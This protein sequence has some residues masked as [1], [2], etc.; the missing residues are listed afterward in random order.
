[1]IDR[2]VVRSIAE[3]STLSATSQSAIAAPNRT[4]I[5]AVVQKLPSHAAANPIPASATAMPGS[6]TCMTRLA[7]IAWRIGPENARPM[8]EPAE[9]IASMSPIP[10]GSTPRWSRR[11]G[12]RASRVAT[13]NPSVAK[14]MK[15]AFRHAFTEIPV[16]PEAVMV[17]E[18]RYSRREAIPDRRRALP[19]VPR[20]AP[21]SRTLSTQGNSRRMG[22]PAAD[23]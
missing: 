6:V 18:Q 21:R 17:T 8:I 12:M 10:P 20:V 11:P 5:E 23:S 7:P 9:N 16:G 15:I 14:T 22:P 1:M 19:V 13:A 3:P 4:E 2:P